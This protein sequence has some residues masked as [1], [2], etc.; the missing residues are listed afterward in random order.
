MT[1]EELVHEIYSAALSILVGSFAKGRI[2]ATRNLAEKFP[3]KPLIIKA[4]EPWK[5]EHTRRLVLDFFVGPEDRKVLAERWE[6]QFVINPAHSIHHFEKF[7]FRFQTFLRTLHSF[8]RLLPL[9]QVMR[10]IHETSQTK[11]LFDIN[12]FESP[13]V[14]NQQFRHD[15]SSYH[16]PRIPSDYPH[17]I[18]ISVAYLSAAV[19]QSV[20]ITPSPS[21]APSQEKLYFYFVLIATML[22]VI[23]VRII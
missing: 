1:V 7:K 15:T 11:V 3:G 9:I 17:S 20:S 23:R 2:A 8:V 16:F 22:F 14:Q 4:V 6:F 10:G 18:N 21:S 5:R 13:A 19:L 12:V